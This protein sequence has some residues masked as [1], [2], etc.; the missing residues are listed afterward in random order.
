MTVDKHEIMKNKTVDKG[1]YCT[2]YKDTSQTVLQRSILLISVF[3][4]CF[5]FPRAGAE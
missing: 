3:P 1:N 5:T 2:E 4:L